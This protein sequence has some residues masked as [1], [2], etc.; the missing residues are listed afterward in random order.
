MQ[1]CALK[2][3]IVRT[4]PTKALSAIGDTLGEAMGGSSGILYN[5]AFNAAAVH[6]AG[7]EA[8]GTAVGWAGALA[9]ATA[10]VMKYGG[11]GK[12]SRTMLDALIPASEVS[13]ELPQTK[14]PLHQRAAKSH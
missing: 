1:L 14:C 2:Y 8:A 6:T 11:A 10:A 7:D 12:G 9:A 4:G 3:A 5:L 13:P